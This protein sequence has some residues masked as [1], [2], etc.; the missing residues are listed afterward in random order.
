MN[1]DSFHL[2]FK[3]KGWNLSTWGF[4]VA[5]Q[6]SMEEKKWLTLLFLMP[7]LSKALTNKFFWIKINLVVLRKTW[8]HT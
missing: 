2:D 4:L 7:A 6:L 1:G 8:E 3:D 5:Y